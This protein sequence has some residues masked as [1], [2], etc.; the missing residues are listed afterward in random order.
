M[1]ICVREGNVIL[2]ENDQ[3]FVEWLV[4]AMAHA[5]VSRRELALTTGM[6]EAA[7]KRW[8]HGSIPQRDTVNLIAAALGSDILEAQ[9][10]AGHLR[11]RDPLELPEPT[12][13]QPVHPLLSTE[14]QQLRRFLDDW[15]PEQEAEC[16]RMTAL[17]GDM[18]PSAWRRL[19]ALAEALDV[20][21]HG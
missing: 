9:R 2:V 13:K 11:R 6:S 1:Y 16:R 8:F 19:R 7:V 15:S 3:E 10:A 4:Q 18:S 5:G 12:S 14:I 20:T 21:N 17:M